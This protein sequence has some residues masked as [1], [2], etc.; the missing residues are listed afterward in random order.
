MY[1]FKSMLFFLYT[2]LK[3]HLQ[4][5]LLEHKKEYTAACH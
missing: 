2:K 5:K 1:K 4:G 3:I